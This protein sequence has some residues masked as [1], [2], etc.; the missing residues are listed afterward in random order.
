MKCENCDKIHDGSFG[1]GRFCSKPCA[2][3]FSTKNKRT[4]ISEKVSKSLTGRKRPEYSEKLKKLWKTEEFRNRKKKE[5]TPINE[6]LII[7]GRFTSKY[8]KERIIK[9]G[10]KE[11]CC[12]ICGIDSYEGNPLTLQ[13]HH[14]N[15]VS[16]DHRIENLQILCPNCHS[17]TDNYCGKNR[18]M[19]NCKK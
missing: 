8:V 12:E 15:G 4:E 3:S 17:Q 7:D 9:D 19:S 1:S 13:L 10:I 18:K 14:I 5:P 16:N 6:V 11:Y 2:R